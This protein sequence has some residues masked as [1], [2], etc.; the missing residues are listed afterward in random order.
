[1]AEREILFRAK[2]INRDKGYHRTNYKN[3]DWVYGL[4]TRLYD[5]RFENLPAEMTDTS[6]VSGIEVDY[7]TIGQYTGL[8]VAN[9]KVFNGDFL[10]FGDRILEVFWNRESFQWQAK[11]IDTDLEIYRSGL[12][13]HYDYGWTITDLGWIAAEEVITGRMTTEIIGNKWD[14]PEILKNSSP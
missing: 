5:E 9:G 10:K 1:M 12:G 7:K 14:N 3:G 13:D 2:A 8:T 6:G 11:Q 4:V